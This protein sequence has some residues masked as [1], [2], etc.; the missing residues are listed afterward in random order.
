M[1]VSKA[2]CQDMNRYLD[3]SSTFILLVALLIVILNSILI[4]YLRKGLME[5]AETFKTFLFSL[6]ISDLL[7][8]IAIILANITRFISKYSGASSSTCTTA[9][10]LFENVIVRGSASCSVITLTAF[11]VV[12]AL[13]ITRQTHY[14]NRK[15]RRICAVIWIVIFLAMLVGFIINYLNPFSRWF[16]WLL[17][18]TLFYSCLLIIV[19]CYLIIHLTLRRSDLETGETRFTGQPGSRNHRNNRSSNESQYF[20]ACHLVYA[21]YHTPPL[22]SLYMQWMCLSMNQKH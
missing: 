5:A 8:G 3:K 1:S 4:F 22:Q 13:N 15:L 10:E 2:D 16:R 7:I 17:T 19:V 20:I 11:T 6:A 18:P 14:S 12:K 9:G 21:Y